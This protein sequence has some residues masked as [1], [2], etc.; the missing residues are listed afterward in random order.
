[1]TTIKTI[2]FFGDSFCSVIMPH[3]GSPVKVDT[4][5]NKLKNFYDAEILNLGVQGSSVE[6]LLLLQLNP[7][8]KANNLPD[9]CI[10]VWTQPGRLFNRNTRNITYSGA[11][12]KAKLANVDK[13]WKDAL[14]YYETFYDKELSEVRYITLMHY[15]DTV[16]LPKVTGKII[17]LWSY[18]KEFLIEDFYYRWTNGVEIRPPLFNI[19]L[20]EKEVTKWY[21]NRPN[22]LGS[23]THNQIIFDWIRLAIDEYESGKL[24]TYNIEEI[25]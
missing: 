8:I 18:G 9:I 25:K 10:F 19:S 15:I 12:R 23:D 11:L 2:G 20:L 1:M 17:H 13:I 7:F 3:I 16:I 24:Y 5:I 14:N 22:H 21:D 4:Y 6:D